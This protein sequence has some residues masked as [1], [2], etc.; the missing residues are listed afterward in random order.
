MR[1][2]KYTQSVTVFYA[3]MCL[4]S[5]TLYASPL[6]SE[7]DSL[8][9]NKLPHAI[10][11][12]L[13]KDLETDQIIYALN[14]DKLLSPASGI[15]ILTA[16]ASL[17][18]FGADYHYETS[19]LR[20]DKNVY[21]RFSGDPSFKTTDLDNLIKQ[22]K[23]Q[24][25]TRIDGNVIIDESRFQ[26][27]YYAAGTNYDDLGWY[28]NAPTSAIILNDNKETFDFVSP[29]KLGQPVKINSK[30]PNPPIKLINNLISVNVE[31][32]RNHCNFNIDI[33]PNNTLRLYG[34]LPQFKDVKKMSLAIPDPMLY[35][36]QV[37]KESLKANGIVL[38]GQIISGKTPAKA[39]LI[40]S[41]QSKDMLK[42]VTHMLRKSDNLYANSFTKLLGIA[43]TQ[44][45]T[46][47]Q[48]AYAIKS[49]IS[50]NTGLKMDNLDISDGEGTRYNLISP[51]QMVVV[52]T[53][54]YKDQT[55][56]DYMAKALP[57]MGKTGSLQWRMRESDLTG[58]VYAKTGTMHD[59]SSLSGY[60]MT[61]SDKPLTF[62]IIINGIHDD[63][64]KAKEFEEKVLQILSRHIN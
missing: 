10:I 54:L 16:T 59:I 30:N 56:R 23:I 49:I 51:A 39:Q 42:L 61:K 62:S 20:D 4:I 55:M 38:K 52:L 46:F 48:G 64:G 25:I 18:Q 45:G 63:I 6:S 34:C 7:L 11:G 41:H 29:V 47:K 26:P 32:E 28:Y 57:H 9:Q 8:I 53:H 43:L 14:D 35:A 33:K 31:Q 50:K 24:Q 37:V 40:V 17:Y 60:M 12:V 2:V 15:K 27:P 58:R 44:E 21:L 3:L 13:V 5:S 1:I 36:K 19:L 22:L